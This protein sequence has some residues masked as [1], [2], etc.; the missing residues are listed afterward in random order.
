VVPDAGWVANL[1]GHGG[2]VFIN[3]DGTMTRVNQ[4]FFANDYN[5][6]LATLRK[7]VQFLE[8]S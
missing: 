8:K 5:E 3:H 1:L 2:D 7:A 4:K 6:G